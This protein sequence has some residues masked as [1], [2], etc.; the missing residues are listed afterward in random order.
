MREI[1]T[2]V[3]KVLP[4]EINHANTVVLISNVIQ[5]GI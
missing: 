1:R 4:V 3:Y 5:A 2:S